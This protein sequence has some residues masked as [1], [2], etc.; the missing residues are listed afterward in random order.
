VENERT[1]R[2]HRRLRRGR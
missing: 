1:D 2:H